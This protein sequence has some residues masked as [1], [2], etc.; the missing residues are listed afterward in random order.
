MVGVNLPS[1][2]CPQPDSGSDADLGARSP[3]PVTLVTGASS[4]IGA[5]LARV[6]A[7]N[8]HALVLI[9]RRIGRLEALA[10]ELKVLGQKAPLLMSC[11][12]AARNAVTD[13]GAALRASN[14]APQFVVNNAGYGLVGNADQLDRADQLGMIDL[15]VRLVTDLSLAFLDS[16][17]LQRGG[18]LNVASVAG[19]LP[20]PRSAVYYASKA[21][22]LSFGEALHAELRSCGVKVTT[23]CPGPVATEFQARSGVLEQ[24]TTWPLGVSARRVAEAGYQG[25]MAGRRVVVPGLPNKLLIA[26]SRIIPRR[27]LLN[28]VDRR[29]RLRSH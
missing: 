2:L 18:L 14:V 19:F 24:R 22:V 10:D 17:Q 4:G 28:L 29:Q 23:L 12:L 13:I 21:F 15:N 7:R 25:L 8:G 3:T 11:D 5:E 16:L 6:F 20:G 9:A 26:C 1:R 27:V